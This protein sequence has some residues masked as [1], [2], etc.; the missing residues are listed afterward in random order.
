MKVLNLYFLFFYFLFFIYFIIFPFISLINNPLFLIL[1]KNSNNNTY[2]KFIIDIYLLIKM[3]IWNEYKK[4]EI[5]K[6]KVDGNIYKVKYKKI[7]NY[8]VS[9]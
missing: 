8:L 7:G 2:F 1:I 6:N 4:I 9:E 5:I 3:S